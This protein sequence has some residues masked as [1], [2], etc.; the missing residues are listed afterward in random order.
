MSFE[1]LAVRPRSPSELIDASVRLVRHHFAAFRP[2]VLGYLA[3]LVALQLVQLVVDEPVWGRT[4]FGVVTILTGVVGYVAG[5][6]ASGAMTAI[7][8]ALLRGETLRT[9]AALRIGM[10]RTPAVLAVGVLMML[11]MVPYAIVATLV[12]ILIG[13]VVALATGGGATLPTATTTAVGIAGIVLMWLLLLVGFAVILG[14]L[15]TAS[16]AVVVDGIGPVAALK[17]AWRRTKGRAAH[18][19][20]TIA[21]LFLIAFVVVGGSMLLGSVA[22]ALG[23][24]RALLGGMTL[25][26]ALASALVFPVFMSASVLLF[27]DLRMRHEGTD[28]ADLLATLDAAPPMAAPAG[29]SPVGVPGSAPSRQ[30]AG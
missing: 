1:P 17:Q 2:L 27:L 16:T 4:K 11:S 19:I 15:W 12:A 23:G 25:A 8:A 21:L 5:C 6:I 7:A 28:V 10:R 26:Q 30:A 3:V 20:G 14:R 22:G 18:A 24:E 9:D 13:V 29:P